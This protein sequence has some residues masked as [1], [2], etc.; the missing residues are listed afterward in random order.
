MTESKRQIGFEQLGIGSVLARHTLRIP[1]NQRE[2]SWTAREVGALFHDLASAI[3]ANAPEYFLGTVV[4]IPV[5]EGVLEIVD[6]QQRL[7]TT[8][9]LL[10]AIK[11]CLAVR[12][13][14]KLLVEDIENKFLTTIDRE[15]R[16]RVPRISLNVTDAAYFNLR[17]M[18]RGAVTPPSASSHSLI[19]QAA[20]LAAK[21]V[22]DVVAPHDAKNHGDVLNRWVGFIEHRAV[23][24][25]LKVPG[26]VNAYKMFETLNDRGL[27]TSQSDL[28]KNYLFGESASDRLQEAQH[29]WAGMKATLESVAD[30]DEMTITFL[31]Q[32]LISLDGYI[33]AP[34][35]YETVQASARGSTGAIG[36]LATMESGASDYAAILNPAHDR[37]NRYPP[38]TRRAVATLIL[39]PMKPLRPILLS[40]TRELEQAEADKVF[41]FLVS[42]SVRLLVVGGARSGSVEQAIASAAKSISAG[43]IS[44]ASGVA[45]VLRD[46]IPTDTQFEEQFRVATVSQAYL[47]RYYLRALEMQVNRQEDPEFLPNDDQSVINLEHILPSN[48]EGNWPQFSPE[49]VDAYHRR[50]G[51]LALLQA[52]KNSDLRSVGFCEKKTVFAESLYH[53]TREIATVDTWSEEEINK[54]QA[55]LAALATMTW[56]LKVR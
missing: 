8:A 23:V 14:D 49:G 4:A 43:T 48:P 55:R 47:A 45:S 44:T 53:L 26:D 38:T 7:A 37:W 54:R 56:P 41:R 3:D 13:A 29:K 9:I 52:K 2:Y 15:A 25:L 30:D 6:G 11:N 39:L 19:D 22:R 16:E 17:V 36:F 5:K 24:I 34:Q 10:A 12:E 40:V 31:R 32:M 35:V 27:R 46:T 42:V 1:L 28:V 20:E 33:R 21:H 50:I 18:Q 51:N